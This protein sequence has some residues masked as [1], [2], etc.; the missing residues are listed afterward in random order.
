MNTI[1]R[2]ILKAIHENKW[3]SIEYKNKGDE[4][5]KYWIGVKEIRLKDKSMIV[6]GLHLSKYATQQLKIYIESILSTSVIDGSYFAVDESLKKDIQ[7]NPQKYK[8]IFHNTINMKILNYLAD[9]NKLDCL[10]YKTDYA[11]IQKLDGD[12]MRRGSYQ[13]SQEQFKEIVSNF[14]MN[15]RSYSMNR[16]IKQLAMNVLSIHTK[17]GLYVLAYR[18]LRLDVKN[19]RLLPENQITI[20][21]EFTVNGMKQSIRKFLDADDYELLEE[22]EQNQELIKD[23]ITQSNRQVSGVDDMPYLIAIGRDV[24]LDLNGEYTEIVKMFEEERASVPIRAFFGELTKAPGRRKDYPIALLNKRINLD[25]LLAIHNAVK[26]PLTYVQGPPG[27]G[28]TNTIV[29]TMITAFF[30][31]KTVLFASYNNHPIDGVCEKLRQ[32]AYHKKG[33]IPFPLIRLGDNE[34]VDQALEDVKE[35]YERMLKV[36]VYDNTLEKNKDIRIARTRELTALLKKH[37]EKLDLLER[38]EALD[39]LWAE[40]QQYLNFQTHLDGVQRKEI[41]RHLEAI[42]EITDEEALKLVL[43]DEEE[44]KKYLYY[45]S[46][47]YIKRLGEPK[48]EDLLDIIYHSN[49]E[50]RV[51][52]FN[53]YLSKAENVKKFLRIFPLVATT[54]ISAHKI[55]EPGTY[56]DMTIMDEASQGNLAVSLVPIIRGKNLMLVGDPQQLKP[57]IVLDARSNEKLKNTYGISPEYDYIG[58]SI[59]K[60][61]LACDSVSGEILLSHHYRCNKKIIEFNNRKYYN[62]KLVIESASGAENPLVLWDVPENTTYYKNTSPEEAEKIAE[63][64]KQNRDKS[65]GVIT[66]FTNQKDCVNDVLKRNGVGNVTCGTVHAFQGDEKDIVLF[67]LALTDKTSQKTYDWLKN[68][69]ELINVA[70][71][72]AKEQLIILSSRKELERLHSEDMDDMYE[73]VQYVETNGKSQVTPRANE[74]RALGIKP[75]STATEMAFLENLN[76]ALG[77][78]LNTDQKCTVKKEVSIAQVFHDNTEYQDLFYTGRFDFVV[79][80]QDHWKNEFPV[81]A[82]E[83]DGK[84]H[85]EDAVV[86]ERDRK[87]NEICRNHGFELIRIENSYARRYHHMK[88][89]LI[90]YFKSVKSY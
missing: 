64:A 30:N 22:F 56:F 27:T 50:E 47:K 49:R 86:M 63:F 40:N 46:A 12:A 66:P 11:L 48:N 15:A 89:I 5:T 34:R 71:S 13:L 37:E 25:Q 3:I 52:L 38:R 82:I 21:T 45:T 76:H 31:E 42:G 75:Y 59:Y 85:F 32:I 78:V 35:L 84:E 58:N 73:L 72:R 87:K 65:I 24:I 90:H 68:N 80:E 28:K 16:K 61:F 41:E 29:N 7:L 6:E 69:K 20:C 8:A 23:R 18:M 43:E 88:E 60:A 14:Q 1:S 74:S 33:F 62:N 36:P 26:Y 4:V 67:S 51:K 81:L 9:C 10:P 77:N 70:T 53:E 17:Q 54:S 55:G 19:K 57:V 79:Y 44:L 83:L 39:K 2:D